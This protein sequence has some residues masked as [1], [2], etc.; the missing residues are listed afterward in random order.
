MYNPFIEIINENES[1]MQ[2]IQQVLDGDT[3]ALAR[4]IYRN[5]AWIYNI[6]LKILIN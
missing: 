5:Q 6:A 2:I 1:D 3:D 4:L